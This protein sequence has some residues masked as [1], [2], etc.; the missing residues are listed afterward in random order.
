MVEKEYPDDFTEEEMQFSCLYKEMIHRECPTGVPTVEQIAAH[1]REEKRKKRQRHIL[2]FTKAACI[3]LVVFVGTSALYIWLDSSQASAARFGWEKFL[4]SLNNGGM[5]TE[6]EENGEN[7]ITVEYT[8]IEEWKDAKKFLPQLYCPAYI[9]E[10]YEFT[11]LSVMKTEDGSYSA[12]Y[13]F[14]SSTDQIYIDI[15]G[16]FDQNDSVYIGGNTEE[17]IQLGI[18]FTIQLEASDRYAVCVAIEDGLIS[19][20][21]SFID[22]D[23]LIKIAEY[24]E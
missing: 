6:Y 1:V 19:V 21:G 9:P 17:G 15:I 24:M 5:S 10:G 14:S 7:S 20:S 16:G 13:I 12:G 2:T 3:V 22:E 23:E 4:H 11:K 18:P 8:D